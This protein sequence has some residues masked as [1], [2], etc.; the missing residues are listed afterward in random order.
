MELAVK[1]GN[2]DS[3]KM[4]LQDERID[5]LMRGNW[6][7]ERACQERNL[8]LVQMIV[9]EDEN[10]KYHVKFFGTHTS[11]NR[12]CHHRSFKMLDMLCKRFK[13]TYHPENRGYLKSIAYDSEA[14]L[15]DFV[16][17]NITSLP[18]DLIDTLVMIFVKQNHVSTLRLLISMREIEYTDVEY[19]GFF[20]EACTRGNLDVVDF[21]LKET[22]LDPSLQSNIAIQLACNFQRLDVIKL[23]LQD[24]RVDPSDNHN[25]AI[26]NACQKEHNCV[27]ELL[28]R[29]QRVDPSDKDCLALKSVIYPENMVILELLVRRGNV[30]LSVCNNHILDTCCREGRRDLIEIIL[31]DPRVNPSDN[32]NSAIQNAHKSGHKGIL[33]MLIN[34]RR[35]TINPYDR[36][37]R[38]IRDLID[39]YGSMDRE[40]PNK[41]QRQS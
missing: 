3:I 37:F 24:P 29:H 18:Q 19:F 6:I 13:F 15:R 31:Q 5:P 9:N 21:F 7:L 28:L 23:L 8:D 1:C 11:F 39:Q 16:F 22:S 30:D 26:I 10:Q 2:L 38:L 32:Q 41:I 40:P 33:P 14:K 25:F 36:N 4:L 35:F 17:Q 20:R 34:D 12:A 27:A